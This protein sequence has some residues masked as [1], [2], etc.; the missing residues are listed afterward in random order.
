MIEL[1]IKAMEAEKLAS[2][3]NLIEKKLSETLHKLME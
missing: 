3:E 2:L 1:V